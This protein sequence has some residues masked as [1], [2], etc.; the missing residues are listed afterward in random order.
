MTTKKDKQRRCQEILRREGVVGPVDH[1]W[2]M[3]EV[4][5]NHEDWP[6]KQGAGVRNILVRRH[7]MFNSVGFILQR[8]DSSEIDISYRTALFGSGTLYGKAVGAARNEIRPQIGAWREANPAPA[9]NMQVDHI[10]SFDA[11]FKEWLGLVGLKAEEISVTTQLVGFQDLFFERS[12]AVSWQRFHNRRA[13]YQ[14][15]TAEENAR[16]SNHVLE[17]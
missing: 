6:E 5:P 7:G 4:F 1:Q 3:S 15:L 17:A 8:A 11:L 16:K 10:E 13:R 14:W 9:A 12:L 2:L